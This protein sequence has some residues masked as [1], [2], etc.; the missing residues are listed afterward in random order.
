MSKAEQLQ[1]AFHRYTNDHGRLPS[2]AREVAEWAVSVGILDLPRID[3]LDVLAQDMSKALREEYKTDDNGRR[4]RV[5]HAVTISKNG[6]QFTFWA[7]LG[8]APRAHMEKA[9]TQ[10]REQIVSDCVQLKTDVDVYNDL[11]KNSPMIQL[12]LDF[13]DDVAERQHWDRS[14]GKE[15]A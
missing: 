4:Y 12:I 8:F 9:F 6:T 7:G 15:V 13:T 1:Q 10:R 11:N 3:P 2:G 5:N 14:N